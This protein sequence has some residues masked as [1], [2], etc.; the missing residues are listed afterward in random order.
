MRSFV[1]TETF[2]HDASQV[3]W[4]MIQ[5]RKLTDNS[6]HSFINFH[7]KINNL[8]E[9][10]LIDKNLYTSISFLASMVRPVIYTIK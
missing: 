4:L 9:K 2:F 8:T 6:L 1:I 10:T 3:G 5:M 7:R